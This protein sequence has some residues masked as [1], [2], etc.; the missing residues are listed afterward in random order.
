MPVFGPVN[1][2]TSDHFELR[3][4]ALLTPQ[5]N[6]DIHFTIPVRSNRECYRNRNEG[7]VELLAE[8]SSGSR[9]GSKTLDDEF[10][11]ASEQV[12]TVRFVRYYTSSRSE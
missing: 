12:R 7:G 2:R 6:G 11:V 9:S 10:G 8:I 5:K 3:D 4:H 1:S